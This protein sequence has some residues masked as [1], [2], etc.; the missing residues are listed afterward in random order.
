M[1]PLLKR[2]KV[3][4]VEVATGVRSGDD[5]VDSMCTVTSLSREENDRPLLRQPSG[6]DDDSRYRAD[7]GGSRRNH[8]AQSKSSF[9][10]ILQR[11]PFVLF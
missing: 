2:R 7:D 6:H 11:S 9:C 10:C 5:G 4:P 8:F 3:N 1:R